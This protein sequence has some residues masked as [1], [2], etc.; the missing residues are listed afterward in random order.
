M[1]TCQANRYGRTRTRQDMP[2]GHT[3]VDL[4]ASNSRAD[5]EPL[6]GRGMGASLRLKSIPPIGETAA[7]LE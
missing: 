1:L 6:G 3:P 2:T 7:E 4:P 5:P